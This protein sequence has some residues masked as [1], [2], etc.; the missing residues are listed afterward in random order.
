MQVF[1]LKDKRR[2][3][4]LLRENLRVMVMAGSV[5]QARADSLDLLTFGF[6]PRFRKTLSEKGSADAL[7]DP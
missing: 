4:T 3:L 6:V 5:L 7:Q 2:T 1:E